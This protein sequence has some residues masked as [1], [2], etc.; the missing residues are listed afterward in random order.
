MFT[1]LYNA[2]IFAIFVNCIALVIGVKIFCKG[3]F[4]SKQFT[5]YWVVSSL[6]FSLIRTV[7]MSYLNYRAAKTNTV[8]Q[9]SY[10]LQ[11]IRFVLSFDYVILDFPIFGRR[12]ISLLDAVLLAEFSPIL[13]E[14]LWSVIFFVG[15]LFISLILVLAVMIVIFRKQFERKAKYKK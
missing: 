10:F 7:A 6:I 1:P 14:L 15:S 5:K 12:F 11:F 9:E 2:I 4:P 8:W 13:E 3:L